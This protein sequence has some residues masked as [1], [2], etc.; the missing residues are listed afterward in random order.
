MF[1]G[2][3]FSA[4]NQY[5]YAEAKRLLKLAMVDLRKDRSLIAGLIELNSQILK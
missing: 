3:Q 5:T 2:F 1:D 4:A